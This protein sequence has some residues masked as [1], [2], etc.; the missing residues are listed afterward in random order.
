MV[1]LAFVALAVWPTI[2]ARMRSCGRP[3]I[4]TRTASSQE[5]IGPLSPEVKHRI[6]RGCSGVLR[7][8]LTAGLARSGKE[9][10][11]R[12][13]S[14]LLSHGRASTTGTLMRLTKRAHLDWQGVAISRMPS[15]KPALY[16]SV[17]RQQQ[18]GLRPTYRALVPITGCWQLAR[19]R[20][21]SSPAASLL[22]I[23]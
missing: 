23:R 6:G 12:V 9:V 14:I 22:T 3:I 5:R 4:R 1:H 13:L 2:S 7:S 18:R 11:E 10:I 20:A 8:E 21:I 19:V 17:A 15:R 16:K